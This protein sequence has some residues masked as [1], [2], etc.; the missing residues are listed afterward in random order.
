[1]ATLRKQVQGPT[2]LT[3]SQFATLSSRLRTTQAICRIGPNGCVFTAPLSAAARASAGGA[4]LPLNLLPAYAMPERKSAHGEAAVRVLARSREPRGAATAVHPRRQAAH[5]RPRGGTL[6]VQ[7][8]RLP[9]PERYARELLAAEH[10][11]CPRRYRQ[12]LA[13]ERLS[14]RARR[15]AAGAN[16]RTHRRFRGRRVDDPAEHAP[17]AARGRA[18]LRL[19]PGDLPAG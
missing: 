11:A 15:A 18:Y 19:Q 13:D 10:Q 8:C 3:R 6:A 7:H 4:R 1:M 5:P 17:S 9:R 16:L 2:P 14:P 12:L